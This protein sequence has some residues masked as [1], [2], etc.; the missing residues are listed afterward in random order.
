MTILQGIIL[1]IIQGLT[2]FLPVSSSGHLVLFQKIFGL[3]EGNMT[4]N[5]AVHIATLISVVFVFREDI[6]KIL[7]KPFAK[8]PLLILTATIPAAVMGFAFSDFFENLYHT[9]AGLGLAFIV[10]GI[11]L[12]YAES[13]RSK[14]K[15]L[16][17]MNYLDATVIGFAQG[18]AILPGV[19]R[20]GLTLASSL[21]RG[22][23]RKFALK[24]SFLMSIPVILGAALKDGYDLLKVGNSINASIEI[25][26]LLAGMAAAAIFGYLT[27][28]F[29]L[30]I[31]SKVTLKVFSY[32]VFAL[33][34][35]VLIDQIFFGVFFD[36][37]F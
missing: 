14:N 25:L 12:W 24:F 20:S 34:G 32:Y 26:P 13:L 17:K 31:F 1:G 6:L 18:L 4:F 15:N 5:I 35:L 7:K 10:T 27:I 23:N 8:L 2:E 21:I 37:F 36:K 3:Q 30:K 28:K 16:T 22:L 33:G 9:G 19:S 29:M 11:C